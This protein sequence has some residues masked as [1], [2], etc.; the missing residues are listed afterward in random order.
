MNLEALS[1]DE[2]LLRTEAV[3]LEGQGVLARLLLHLVEIEDRRLE[4]RRSYTSLFDFC[5]RKLRMADSEAYRRITAARLVRKFPALVGH[6]E[7]GEMH[8]STLVLLH[9]HLTGEN[10]DALI[11]ATSGK[12][13][14]EVQTLLA[15]RAPK[16]DVPSTIREL[17]TEA[18]QGTFDLAGL[19]APPPRVE[20]LSA[21]RHVVQFTVSTET[22][23]KLEYARDLLRHANPSGDLG[24][25]V[26]RALTLL[27][28]K[29]EK[30]KLA[31]ADKP[32]A[33]KEPTK[34]TRTIPRW[35]ERAV[36]ERDGEQ[37]TYVGANGERCP[38]TTWLEIEHRDPYALGGAHTLENLCLLCRAHNQLRREEVFGTAIPKR[39]KAGSKAE[40]TPTAP[41]GSAPP[42]LK[43][44]D[45]Q[46]P[47]VVADT[48][49]DAH[50]LDPE[51]FATATR[52]LVGMGFGQRDVLR[53]LEKI[54]TNHA[55]DAAPPIVDIIR[56]AIRILSA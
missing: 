29:L 51:S 47:L 20:P 46:G 1:D 9:H 33:P 15:A 14:R 34:R 12:T 22:R 54:A 19:P 41:G 45:P 23:D 18:P 52:G 30:E 32:R 48:R 5:C 27:V 8:L 53:A 49:V 3:H 16:P 40:R 36:R 26:D 31:R 55:P 28:A 7:R 21:T 35:L 50:R 38:A 39:A 13:K 56:K 4:L 24:E 2:L 17:P 43:T 44:S 42:P 25:V 37:C 6:I 11:A 10:F